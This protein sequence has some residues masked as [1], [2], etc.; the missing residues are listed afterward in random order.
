MLIDCISRFKTPTLADLGSPAGRVT[1]AF[2]GT[3]GVAELARRQHASGGTTRQAWGGIATH[4]NL[5]RRIRDVHA[6]DG[7]TTGRP[8]GQPRG[9]QDR[10]GDR[11]GRRHFLIYRDHHERRPGRR[12]ERGGDGHV[13][14]DGDVRKRHRWRHA[15]RQRRHLAHHREPGQRRDPE[16]HRD[17]D[18]ARQRRRCSTS[19]RARAR[20]SIRCRATTT[21]QRLVRGSPRR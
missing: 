15:E 9:D 13:A 1:A 17:G 14:S 3:D 20:Q 18:G 21:A 11:L 2:V 7:G 4:R 16:L 5:V 19:P 10:A 6:H 8:V 12:G